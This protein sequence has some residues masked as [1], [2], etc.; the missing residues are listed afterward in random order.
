MKMLIIRMLLLTS[1]ALCAGLSHAS[2]VVSCAAKVDHSL[3]YG[4]APTGYGEACHDTPQWQ[5]LGT[6]W[7]SESA[8]AN[9]DSE[10]DGV[11]WKIKQEDGSWSDWSNSAELQQGDTVKFRFNFTRSTTGQEHTYDQLKAWVDLNGDN[12]WTDQGIGQGGELIKKVTWQKDEE[13]VK[14]DGKKRFQLDATPSTNWNTMGQY[15]N[16]NDIQ[17]Y[18]FKKMTIPMDSVIGDTWMRVRVACSESI[19]KYGAGVLHATGY[20]NQGEV[21]DYLLTIKAAAKKVPVPEPSTFAVVM[22]GLF[23]LM[24]R[25]KKSI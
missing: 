15:Y 16:S 9:S 11:V 7:D 18:F 21:E 19:D 23:A 14:V 20:Y 6:E 13:Y 8:S 17:A 3:D 10:D 12:S 25:R 5:R 1:L 4:D 22:A 2:S 24:M